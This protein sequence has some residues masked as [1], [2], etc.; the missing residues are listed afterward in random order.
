MTQKLGLGFGFT[1]KACFVCGSYNHLIKNYDFHEK[2]MAKSVLKD[3]GKV[4][5]HREVRPVW[6]NT[7]RINHYN[8]FIPSAVL[9]RFGRVP[10]SS[11]K[12]SSFK[13][14]TSTGAVKQVNTAT[15]T[16]RVNVSKT[17][18]NI[19]HKSHSP[20]RRP[21]YKSTAPNTSISNE[22]VN[23]VR[24]KGVNTA[25]QTTIS[26]VKGNGVTAV[27]ASAG[28]VLRPKMTDLNNVSKD[29]SGSWV[30]KRENP[31]QALKNKGIFN[32]GCSRHM[33]GNKDFPTDY[34]DID[35]GFVAFNGSAIG[36]K[37][38]RKGKIKTDKLDFEDVFFVKELKFISFS[39]SQMCDKK[40]SVHFTET[41]CLV[42]SHGFKLLNESHVLLRVLGKAICMVSQK[43]QETVQKR[44]VR[45]RESEEYNR[46]PKSHASVIFSQRKAINGQTKSTKPFLVL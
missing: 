24:V 15:H 4:T 33:T 30:S 13:A 44:A 43:S 41:E 16:N 21:F 40:N 5:Y 27:K 14:A 2:R 28:C 39:V 26:V 3:M 25:R 29:N 23:T 46:S 9:T 35:G 22:I 6:N 19:F 1:K 45:T 31:Q 32:S 10:V 37:I 34:Q 20:I 36:G 38:T 7:Q 17:R 12:Q 42:L 11:A 8:K 18:T